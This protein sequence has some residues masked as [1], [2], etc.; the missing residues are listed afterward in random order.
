MGLASLRP[1]TSRLAAR[2]LRN[3]LVSAAEQTLEI[4]PGSSLR[5]DFPVMLADEPDRIRAHLSTSHPEVN[6]A[7]LTSRC[8]VQG[9]TRMHLL[10]DV[11]IADG[12]L[13]TA[14]SYDR[15]APGSPRWFLRGELDEIDEAAF[16]STYVSQKYFGHWLVD[17]RG[18]ELLATDYNLTPLVL[19]SRI[20]THEPSYRRLL[21]MDAKRTN[22]ARCNR[23]WILEDHEQNGHF[24]ARYQRLRERIGEQAEG[25]NGTERVFLE[26]GNQAKGRSLLNNEEIKSALTKLGWTILEPEKE[27][28]ENI[29]QALSNARIIVSPEGSALSHAALAARAGSGI[30]TIIGAEHFNMPFKGLC[31]SLGIVFGFTIADAAEEDGFRQ[32]LDRLLRTIDL[33]DLSVERKR[34]VTGEP[35]RPWT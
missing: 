25:R 35:D 10:R 1:I 24:I 27:S 22:F 9:P 29:V 28:A 20:W 14:S 32:P 12:T 2:L 33:M 16:C 7:R 17:A 19:N 13:L 8:F 6:R 18:H 11:I 15:I 26:R 34:A 5:V 4:A 21:A 30:L 3:Q 23:L 31:D